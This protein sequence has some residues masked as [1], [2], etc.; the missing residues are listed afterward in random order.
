MDAA[1][2]VSDYPPTPR[3]TPTRKRDRARYDAATV[4]AVL[5]ADFICHLGFVVDGAPVV[6]PTIYARVDDRLYL[7]GSTGSRPMRTAAGDGLPVCLTVTLPQGIVLAR[8]ALHHSVNYRSVV[9][10]GT[11]RQ[12]TDP[13]EVSLAFAALIDHMLPGRAADC[14]PP[15][16]KEQAM[17]TVLR[18]DL[19]EV[20]AKIRSGGVNDDPEDMGLAHWAGLLPLARVRQ[21]PVPDPAMAPGTAL[22]DYLRAA[23]P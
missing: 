18:L 20:S 17:T 19:R 15:T 8:S 9:A 16:P 21:A 4:H 10:H 13:E 2:P 11:A 23:A 14:R 22:P 6:L 5:D 3:T 12:V 1:Q 7:H